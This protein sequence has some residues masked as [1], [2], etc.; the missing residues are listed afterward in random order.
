MRKVFLRAAGSSLRRETGLAPTTSSAPRS[1]A[2]GG[3]EHLRQRFAGGG[4]KIGILGECAGRG[5]GNVA[6]QQVREE[7]HVG[8]AAGVGVVAEIGEA[9]VSALEAPGDEVLDGLAAKLL[10]EEDDERFFG[11]DGLAEIG[12]AGAEE[13]GEVLVAIGRQVLHGFG[14]A[15]EL[16]GLG[17]GDVEARAVEAHVGAEQPGEE[18]MLFG[19]VAADEQDG[20]GGGDVA[21]AGGFAGAVRRGRGQRQA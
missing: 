17:V 15:V 9:D 12:F 10:A 3:F 1:P 11:E 21:Q 7:A 5:D 16:D 19:G 6:G 4:G 13:G 8:S 20:G 18:R 2:G 14:L